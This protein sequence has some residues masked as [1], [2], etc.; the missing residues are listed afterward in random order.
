MGDEDCTAPM[1]PFCDLDNGVCVGCDETADPDGSCA[2]ADP[3]MPV[4]EGAACV[5]CT[6]DVQSACTGTTPICDVA[7]NV[8]VGC[9]DHEQ[10]S[11]SACN[12]AEGNCFD[13]ANILHVDGNNGVICG[14]ADG[15]EAL[16]YCT[17]GA[18]IVNAPNES[19]IV[20]HELIGE[21]AYQEDTTVTGTLA[22]FA[23]VGDAPI[24]RGFNGN[25]AVTVAVAGTLF[26]RGI[27]ISL[28]TAPGFRVNGGAAWVESSRIVNN[29]G[30]GWSLLA[31]VH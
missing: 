30:G 16:P 26:M 11:D 2:G 28:S 4:C 9:V 6:A 13:P 23:A 27:Q 19:V 18:A 10:C 3:N 29:P 25:P 7:G 20:I 14:A 12:F 21:A 22:M 31:A 17:V 5:Q 1:M 8:C 24:L 15:S